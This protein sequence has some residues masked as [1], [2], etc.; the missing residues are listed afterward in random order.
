M[1]HSWIVLLAAGVLTTHAQAGEV[2]LTWQEPEKYADIRSTGETRDAFQARV[3]EDLSKVFVDLAKKLPDG[4]TWI[5]TVTDVD[6]AG[7]V[8]P[9]MRL[10]ISDIRVVKDGYWPRMS[11][12][13]SMLD[14]KGQVISEGQED[15]KDMSFMFGKLVTSGNSSFQYEE[16]MLR[17]WFKR[18][19]RDKLFPAR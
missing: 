7:E 15:I 13:Y 17:D 4:V 9:M 5:V 19:Q 8:R 2:K 1:K 12:R 3:T 11:I 6:L 16:R 14:A 10:G 18:Q